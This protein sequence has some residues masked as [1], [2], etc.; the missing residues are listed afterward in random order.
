MKRTM[1]KWFWIWDFD[2]EEKWLNEMAVQG[3]VLTAVSNCKYTFEDSAPGSY[4][5][6]LELLDN[7]PSHVLSQ[8]Y[9]R[10]L[11]ETGAEYLGSVM[12]WIY[13]RK[14]TD[15][16]EFNLFSDYESRIRHLNRIIYLNTVPIFTMFAAMMSNFSAYHR[17]GNETN[18]MIFVFCVVIE[19]LAIVGLHQ[20]HRKK[21]RLQKEKQIFES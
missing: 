12:R 18:F 3:L 19:L 16:E 2:K 1:Y 9:L 15:G 20:I 17:T 6:R 4:R 8:K 21:K 13:V 7:L 14:K 11:E 10:F 5:V